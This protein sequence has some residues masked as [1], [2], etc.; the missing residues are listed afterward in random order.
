MSRLKQLLAE[1]IDTTHNFMYSLIMKGFQSLVQ[2]E[3]SLGEV[4]AHLLPSS[5]KT[6]ARFLQVYHL[7]LSPR[8][9]SP[10]ELKTYPVALPP[11]FTKLVKRSYARCKF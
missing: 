6:M 8:S 11:L 1:E 2:L 4:L 5:D 3:A 10:L 7:L 9:P